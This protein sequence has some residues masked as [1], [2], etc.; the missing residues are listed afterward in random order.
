MGVADILQEAAAAPELSVRV[1]TVGH[2]CLLRSTVS[3]VQRVPSF[4]CI[5]CLCLV[6]HVTAAACRLHVADNQ[7]QHSCWGVESCESSLPNHIRRP[8]WQISCRYS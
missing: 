3:A 4:V 8:Q 6:L 2:I 7:Q 1:G 5:D